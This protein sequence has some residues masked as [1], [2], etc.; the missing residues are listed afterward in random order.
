LYTQNLPEL[1][2]GPSIEPLSF[3]Y[4]HLHRS[5]VKSDFLVRH[6][7]LVSQQ[8]PEM[9]DTLLVDLVIGTNPFELARRLRVIFGVSRVCGLG[10]P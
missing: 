3:I 9:V 10:P 8:P 2:I 1:N 7:I 5:I 6:G 4:R